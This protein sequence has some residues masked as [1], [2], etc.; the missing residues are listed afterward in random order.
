[1]LSPTEWEAVWLSSANQSAFA[2]SVEIPSSP[3]D[4]RPPCVTGALTSLPCYVTSDDVAMWRKEQTN[5]SLKT[6]AVLVSLAIVTLGSTFMRPNWSNSIDIKN[7]QLYHDI[8]FSDNPTRSLWWV[9]RMS[10]TPDYLGT[11]TK[12]QQD[13]RTV[14]R[15]LTSFSDKTH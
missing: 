9:I 2:I 5:I 7:V 10:K 4:E 8:I 6:L 1:M 15:F 12:L 3:N 11:S 13:R 14:P